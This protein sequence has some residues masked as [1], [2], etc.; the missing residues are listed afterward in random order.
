M[1]TFI[2]QM[3]YLLK[4]IYYFGVITKPLLGDLGKW[5]RNGDFKGPTEIYTKVWEKKLLQLRPALF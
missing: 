1:Q 5:P 4:K 3:D 2:E